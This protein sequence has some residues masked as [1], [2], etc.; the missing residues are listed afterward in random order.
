MQIFPRKA[1][2]QFQT[3]LAVPLCLGI[4]AVWKCQSLF[5]FLVYVQLSQMSPTLVVKDKLQLSHLERA[6]QMECVQIRF[7]LRKLLLG[8]HASFTNPDRDT[9]TDWGGGRKAV[10]PLLSPF[11]TFQACGAVSALWELWYSH[12]ASQAGL[13]TMTNPS[14]RWN[15]PAHLV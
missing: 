5:F 2:F 7:I 4:G 11:R 8:N 13:Q 12:P 15:I 6:G 10:F 9:L 3:S 14:S 1:L